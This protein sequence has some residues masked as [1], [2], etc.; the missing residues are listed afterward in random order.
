MLTPVSYLFHCRLSCH[1][2]VTLESLEVGYCLPLPHLF[3]F[4]ELKNEI[5]VNILE[6]SDAV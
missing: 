5:S 6:L 2:W 4:V 1:L 3:S